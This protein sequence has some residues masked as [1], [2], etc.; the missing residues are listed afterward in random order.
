MVLQRQEGLNKISLNKELFE[1]A[2]PYMI[3]RQS[4]K[5]GLYISSGQIT[6]LMVKLTYMHVQLL[7]KPHEYYGKSVSYTFA[8]LHKSI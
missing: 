7:I 6:K 4:L 8:S 5:G 3:I 1:N 2:P